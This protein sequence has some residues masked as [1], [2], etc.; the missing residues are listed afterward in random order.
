MIYRGNRS[1]VSVQEQTNP[2]PVPRLPPAG[3]QSGRTTPCPTLNRPQTNAARRLTEGVELEKRESFCLTRQGDER[4]RVSYRSSFFLSPSLFFFPP[5]SPPPSSPTFPAPRRPA[6]NINVEK[7][8]EERRR[9]CGEASGGWLRGWI[10]A[11][12]LIPPP[13]V[14]V[15]MCRGDADPE[16]RGG[17]WGEEEEGKKR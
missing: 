17:V 1:R 10:S 12:E 15:C 5:F 7:G 13:R 14:Y 11:S 2:N 8:W 9:W 4:G 3:G 6:D 16:R